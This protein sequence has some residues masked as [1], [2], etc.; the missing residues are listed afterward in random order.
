[1]KAM[2]VATIVG[3]ASNTASAETTETGNLLAP[4]RHGPMRTGLFT[5][6]IDDVDVQG[7]QSVTIPGSSTEQG[8]YRE[9]EDPD[10]QEEN[11]EGNETDHERNL[12]GQP[13]Y[14]DLEMERG[15]FRDDPL[16]WEWRKAVEE[17]RV[18]EALKNVTVILRDEEGR[19]QISWEFTAA[20]PKEYDPPELDASAGGDIATESITVAYDR[21]IREE[22]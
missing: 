19:H 8:Q 3:L 6:E 13:T 14:D 12:W 22:V 5:V 11:G 15:V 18:E 9:G 20:W 4:D 7:W 10:Q 1:M 16:I 2:G 21:M 17:G